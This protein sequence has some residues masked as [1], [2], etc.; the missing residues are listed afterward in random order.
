VC[1]HRLQPR[2]RAH[3]VRRGG[4]HTGDRTVPRRVIGASRTLDHRHVRP[5]PHRR[6]RARP[7]HPPR[8]PHQGATHR[9]ATK[10]QTSAAPARYP[11]RPNPPRWSVAAAKCAATPR[12]TMTPGSPWSGIAIVAPSK[13]IASYRT[14]YTPA[15]GFHPSKTQNAWGVRSGFAAKRN[16]SK[17]TSA[18]AYRRSKPTTTPDATTGFAASDVNTRNV[19]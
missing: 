16:T 8:H 1:A 11:H 2:T 15:L 14:W 4:G 13:P 18:R 6:L 17:A 12:A 10:K 19:R 5:T 3:M 9:N 7:A